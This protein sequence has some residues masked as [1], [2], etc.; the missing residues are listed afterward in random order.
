MYRGIHEFKRSYQ[1][2]NTLVKDENDDLLSDSHS[3]L[4][5][6]N[7]FSPLPNLHD[8]SDVRQK[9][10][11]T[12]ELL[13]PTP[14]RLGVDITI[15]KLKSSKSPCNDEIPTTDSSRR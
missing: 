13:V 3:I 1:P 10:V 6:W 14:S 11:H 8:I 7:Y 5:S 12:G 2:R 9:E 4:N 15:A